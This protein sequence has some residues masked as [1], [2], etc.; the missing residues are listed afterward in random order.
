MRFCVAHSINF[1][2]FLVSSFY[3]LVIFKAIPSYPTNGKKA[4]SISCMEFIWIL[5]LVFNKFRN[6]FYWKCLHLFCVC[7]C[8]SW[9]LSIVQLPRFKSLMS[10]GQTKPDIF[11]KSFFNNYSGHYIKWHRS[12]VRFV[13]GGCRVVV[14][15][16]SFLRRPSPLFINCYTY[17]DCRSYKQKAH[18]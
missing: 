17:F 18:N 10:Y 11:N 3:H 5:I 15:A 13:D 1:F 7:V 2:F 8:V 4:Q 16:S 9:W 12:L 6:A 14:C